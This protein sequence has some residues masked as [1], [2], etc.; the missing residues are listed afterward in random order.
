MNSLFSSCVFVCVEGYWWINCFFHACL[1]VLK[2]TEWHW[3]NVRKWLIVTSNW[4][5]DMKLAGNNKS[6]EH[7]SSYKLHQLAHLKHYLFFHIKN[8]LPS[9]ITWKQSQMKH[10]PRLIKNRFTCDKNGLCQQ[11]VLCGDF[12]AANSTKLSTFNFSWL[13]DQCQI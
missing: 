3:E 6:S 12:L 2:V 1:S 5:P 7:P 11:C 13:H 4:R 8:H 10:D 9:K